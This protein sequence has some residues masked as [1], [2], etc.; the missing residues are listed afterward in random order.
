MIKS[1]ELLINQQ[2]R[3]MKGR[4][5]AAVQLLSLPFSASLSSPLMREVS[6]KGGGGQHSRP[7][8]SLSP[9]PTTFSS[10][11]SAF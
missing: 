8:P 4:V 5:S 3:R 2:T 7:H 9:I 10:N 1:T 6:G 11:N